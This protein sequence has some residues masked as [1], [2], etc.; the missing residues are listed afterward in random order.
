[1]FEYIQ[2][3][4]LDPRLITVSSN[5]K[6]ET[7]RFADTL[8]LKSLLGQNNTFV[9]GVGDIIFTSTDPLLSIVNESGTIYFSSSFER[10][11][12]KNVW[13]DG[14]YLQNTVEFVSDTGFTC[15][16]EG[17]GIRLNPNSVHSLNTKTGD[18]SIFGLGNTLLFTDND[19]GSISIS[20]DTVDATN[21][22]TSSFINAKK[23]Q[24]RAGLSVSR[25]LT[26]D[27]IQFTADS[28]SAVVIQG[29]SSVT[30]DAPVIGQVSASTL[31]IGSSTISE[32]SGQIIFSGA[33]SLA[34][35]SGN[36]LS[37]CFFTPAYSGLFSNFTHIGS[38]VYY[39]SVPLSGNPLTLEIDFSSS[40]VG[41]GSDFSSVL[42]F[43][44]RIYYTQ[45]LA[46]LSS[47]VSSKFI[48]LMDNPD[49]LTGTTLT[50]YYAMLSDLMGDYIVLSDFGTPYASL[51]GSIGLYPAKSGI[52]LPIITGVL[53]TGTVNTLNS[54][55]SSKLALNAVSDMLDLPSDLVYYYELQTPS[56]SS[57]P[58]LVLFL[59][60]PTQI[61]PIGS[62]R[63]IFR[64]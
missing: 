23:V 43:E 58:N 51:T 15:T 22:D 21:I 29:L 20:L 24:S 3:E 47:G 7:S 44:E 59:K 5:G 9:G 26:P 16:S 60:S 31:S 17:L 54:F 36:H 8:F 49:S 64:V 25:D 1:M 37:A 39:Q 57:T 10:T 6:I 63:G 33:S 46:P 55:T 14:R 38:G 18:I 2:V 40:N 32:N 42:S 53:T 52:Y 48:S 19:Q 27:F 61:P 12:V 41:F 4:N 45:Q 50:N 30:V 62:Y 28:N 34:L 13:V 11:L 56:G 35:G